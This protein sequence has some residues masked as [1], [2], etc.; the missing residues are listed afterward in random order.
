MSFLK[1]KANVEDKAK[2]FAILVVW[3]PCFVMGKGQKHHKISWE[4]QKPNHP[5]Y[6]FQHLPAS[7]IFS[8]PIGVPFEIKT[9]SW[10]TW[11]DTSSPMVSF[12]FVLAEPFC[13]SLVSLLQFVKLIGHDLRDYLHRPVL[14]SFSQWPGLFQWEALAQEIQDRSATLFAGTLVAIKRLPLYGWKTPVVK[15]DSN[16]HLPKT[17]WLEDV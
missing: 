1:T 3:N 17:N 11:G 5:I 12:V 4:T 2:G 10:K 9:P 13:W 15:C 14:H 8:W 7:P 16:R 6:H